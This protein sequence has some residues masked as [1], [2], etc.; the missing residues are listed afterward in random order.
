M[1]RH[2]AMIQC[3]R[4]AFG[5]TGI[6]DQDEAERITER[7]VGGSEQAVDIGGELAAIQSAA[8]MDELQGAF[9]TAWKAHTGKR[10]RELLTNTKDQRKRELLETPEPI[11]GEYLEVSNG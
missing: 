4:L 1:M 9:A 5:F 10:E 11:E 8:S 2:K 6:F 7:D 3:A